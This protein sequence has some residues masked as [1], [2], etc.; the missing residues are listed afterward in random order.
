MGVHTMVVTSAVIPI[1][2]EWMAIPRVRVAVSIDGLPE[3]HDVRRKP[4]TYERILQNIADCQVNIHGTIT[5]PMLSRAGYLDEYLAFWNARAE[6]VRIWLSLYTPQV[7]ERSPEMLSPAQRLAVAEEL[8]SLQ[9]LYP[10]LLMNR[11]IA[12]AIQSP[13]ANPKQCLFSKLSTNYSA[14]LKTQVEPCIFGGMPD[15]SQCGCAISSGLHWLKTI[16][17]GHLIQI[18]TLVNASIRVGSAVREL[19]GQNDR[20]S[21]WPGHG[22]SQDDLVRITRPSDLP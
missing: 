13:P 16:R 19:G 10:K 1:P 3:H 2:K 18:E 21:R 8:Q 14:D 5:A 12:R 6:V 7:N 9:P 4:A 15:C 11:G 22:G 20:H 17:V